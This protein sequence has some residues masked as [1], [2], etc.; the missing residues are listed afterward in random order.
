MLPFQLSSGRA[1]ET[2]FHLLQPAVAGSCGAP[3]THGT[4]QGQSSP[5][6]AAADPAAQGTSRPE[7]RDSLLTIDIPT[8][9][10][11]CPAHTPAPAL[12]SAAPGNKHISPSRGMWY[13]VYLSRLALYSSEDSVALLKTKQTRK[14]ALRLHDELR[15]P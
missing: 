10:G 2:L 11:A 9:P 3:E 7:C 13:F 4:A 14:A 8:Q 1:R 6:A 15:L 5:S 12:A